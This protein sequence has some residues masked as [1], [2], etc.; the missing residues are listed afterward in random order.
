MT[1]LYPALLENPEHTVL[2]FP[3]APA[4]MQISPETASWYPGTPGFT[5]ASVVAYILS[6][7]SSGPVVMA[8]EQ[9][10]L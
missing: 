1:P 5:E 3:Y 10:R 7:Y 9:I 8:F 4:L 6:I 2:A